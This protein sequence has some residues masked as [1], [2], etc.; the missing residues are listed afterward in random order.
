MQPRLRAEDR[1]GDQRHLDRELADAAHV[2]V[3]VD[4]EGFADAGL[5]ALLGSGFD[6]GLAR[7]C[8]DCP[9]SDL[10]AGAGAAGRG[11]GQAQWEAV[12]EGSLQGII[13]WK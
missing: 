6:P 2:A 13:Q 5:T 9:A 7:A 11:G 10:R 12:G 4:H 1:V 8:G 3:A